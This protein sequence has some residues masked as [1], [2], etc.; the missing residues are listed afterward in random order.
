MENNFKYEDGWI[1]IKERFP[2]PLVRVIICYQSG[3]MMFSEMMPCKEFG[4]ETFYGPVTHW[5][6]C[7]EPPGAEYEYNS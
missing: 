3:K 5:R 2:E 7:P 1:P 6:P 4:L